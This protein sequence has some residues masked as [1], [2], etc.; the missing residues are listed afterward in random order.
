MKLAMHQK[1]GWDK[2]QK[3]KCLEW[4]SSAQQTY[5][6]VMTRNFATAPFLPSLSVAST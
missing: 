3:N 4:V 2:T 1:I 6:S 5:H